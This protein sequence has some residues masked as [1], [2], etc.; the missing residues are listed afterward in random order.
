MSG[1]AAAAWSAACL[2]GVLLTTNPAYRALALAACLAAVL[3]GAG[4]RRTRPLLVGVGLAVLSAVML[5]LAFSHFGADP[6]FVLSDGWVLIGGPWTLEALAFGLASGLAVAAAVLAVAPLSLL[7]EPH[8]VVDALPAP[9][10]RTGAAAAASLNLVPGL[11]RSFTAI[12]EAQRMRGWRPRGPAS[13]SE[14]VVPAVLTAIEDSIQL[15]EAMEAR[16]FGSGPRTRFR[17]APL[18]RADLLL[19]AGAALS[20]ALLVAARL[21]GQAADWLPYPYLRLPAV[22][23][24]GVIAYLPLFLPAWLWRSLR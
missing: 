22:T 2:L 18:V 17:P 19:L 9:L 8:Q 4:W 21:L 7:L 15:A 14:V 6:L 20:M 16:G 1:R 11:R 3:T 5:N 10:A 13:W 12:A 24:L 23:P